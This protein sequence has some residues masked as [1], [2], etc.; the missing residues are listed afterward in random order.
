[1]A[2]YNCKLLYGVSVSVSV[3]F[4]PNLGG[5]GFGFGR[6]QNWGFGGSLCDVMTTYY[7]AKIVLEKYFVKTQVSIWCLTLPCGFSRNNT[8]IKRNRFYA[9]NR[10]LTATTSKSRNSCL[11]AH[12]KCIQ[13]LLKFYA[14][15]IINLWTMLAV[16]YLNLQSNKRWYEVRNIQPL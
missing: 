11:F 10:F 7:L 12:S 8:R 6:N 16:R 2:V 15:I 1:M 5:F 14:N 3:R 4:R 9:L 13:N